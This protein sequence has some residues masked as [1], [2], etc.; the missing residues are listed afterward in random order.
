[1]NVLSFALAIA[2][3]VVF[4]GAYRGVKWGHLG[5]GLALLTLS[6]MFQLLWDNADLIT[7]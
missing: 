4:A 3:L 1:M 5:L 7:L 2:A 6:W